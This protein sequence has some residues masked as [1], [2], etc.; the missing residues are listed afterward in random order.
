VRT[1]LSRQSRSL[2]FKMAGNP[3]R[4]SFGILLS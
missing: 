2:V 3:A 4:V 1:C